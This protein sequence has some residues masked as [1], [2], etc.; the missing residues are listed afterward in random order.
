MMILDS[1]TLYLNNTAVMMTS[2]RL[3]FNM[4]SGAGTFEADID[5]TLVIDLSAGPV[6]FKIV[7][8]ET[9]MM[10]GYIERVDRSYLKTDIRQSIS[11]RDMMQVLIDNY[12]AEPHEY[13]GR[14]VAISPL[15]KLFGQN[16]SVLSSIPLHAI[17]SDVWNSSKQ[18]AG[19]N[20]FDDSAKG[21]IRYTALNPVFQLPAINFPVYADNAQNHK[22]FAM[23]KVRVGHGQSLFEFISHMCNGLGLY[24]YNVPGTNDI[25]I[26][27]IQNSAPIRSYNKRCEPVDTVLTIKNKPGDPGNNVIDGRF[28]MDISE[29]YK[30]LRFIGQCQSEET[31]YETAGRSYLVTEKIEHDDIG[32]GYTGLNKFKAKI[33]NV[34][35]MNVWRHEQGRLMANELM[36]QNKKLYGLEYTVAGHSP[37]GHTPYFFNVAANV[38]DDI[39]RI[40]NKNFLVY[41]VE[42]NGSKTAGQTTR[43]SLYSPSE[44]STTITN[45]DIPSS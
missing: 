35:D 8:D 14:P 29:Y 21:K 22:L 24:L 7:I 23:K 33:I 20:V 11:G 15:A 9:P 26:H 6:Q 34:L 10:L 17:I 28:N 45:A 30:M 16:T 5:H 43:L 12:V 13:P 44:V 1:I 37:D 39:F 27:S 3:T 18:V 2:Y 38:T 36:E 4:F 31:L 25:L 32:G 40:S 41:G 42:Y 19:V